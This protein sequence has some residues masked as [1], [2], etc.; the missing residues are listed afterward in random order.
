MEE[1]PKETK[2]EGEKMWVAKKF[3]PTDNFYAGDSNDKN[4]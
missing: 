2:R 1:N 3:A 4:L